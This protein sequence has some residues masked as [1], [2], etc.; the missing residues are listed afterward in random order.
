MLFDASI[1]AS[2]AVLG[3]LTMGPEVDASRDDA[4][5][6]SAA[7]H[8]VGV[9][10]VALLLS[11]TLPVA[12]RRRSPLVAYACVVTGVCVAYATHYPA[13]I[14]S[15]SALVILYTVGA[16]L[17]RMQALTLLGLALAA[18]FVITKLDAFRDTFWGTLFS[19]GIYVAAW[20]LGRSIRYRRAYTA[21][22]ESRAQR[23]E[24]ERET[25]LRA[26][27]AEERSRI[28]RELHDV[29][30]H[31]L[32]VMTVQAAAAQRTA[33]RDLQRSK[34][35]MAA[36]ESTGRAALGEMRRIVGVLREEGETA[37][38]A[39][40]PG[41]ADLP[42]LVWQVREAGLA[43]DMQLREPLVAVPPGSTSPS[44][45]SCRRRSPTR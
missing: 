21:E 14:G 33:D 23:L 20:A 34:E 41:M 25:E 15:V 19:A 22:L 28:A 45:A 39:P 6:M 27:L 40:S 1:A 13:E 16:L 9:T 2:L 4:R 36:V 31:S 12:L 7:L 35:A 42:A 26:T 5:S 29:V 37:E 43:V 38:L 17:E 24:S 10:A 11:Y 44:T 18:Y 32:S 8:P 30:A 3:L